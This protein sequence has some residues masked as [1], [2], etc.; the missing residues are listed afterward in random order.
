MS[1]LLQFVSH[2]SVMLR[3]GESFLLTDPWFETPAFSTWWPS[4][5]SPVSPELWISLARAGK[6]TLVISHAHPDH[7]DPGFLRR[8]PAETPVVIPHYGDDHL[9]R[10]L[11]R[12]GLR[13]LTELG[14]GESPIGPFRMRFFP[15]HDSPGDGAI[16]IELPDLFVF[17]GNDAWCLSDPQVEALRSVKPAGKPDLFMGQGGSASG[18]PLT[19]SA[20]S[21]AE[22][23][24]LL[25]K[26][27]VSMLKGLARSATE[28]GFR[29]A[30]AY[31][32]FYTVHTPERTYHPNQPVADGAY[33]NQVTG[34]DLFL[35]LSPGDLYLPAE[36]RVI[37]LYPTLRFPEETPRERVT[38]PEVSEA[39][40]LEKYERPLDDFLT[41]LRQ[42]CG[43]H[44]LEFRIEVGGRRYAVALAPR[45]SRRK[46]C[47][48]SRAILAAVL[49]RRIP[50]EDLYVGY[51][52][53]WEREPADQYN[54]AFILKL[55]QYGYA[56]QG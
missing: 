32:C 23:K 18:Y 37:S 19:Y 30:L 45:P 25:R 43:E 20:H 16:S 11:E 12:C 27:N 46:T 5:A 36:D 14:K 34:T 29:R 42:F 31:A 13:N 49:D 48:V 4:P 2:A 35:P 28:A 10:L 7:A 56:Y 8:L 38:F 41:G 26:K 55:M 1:S 47:R 50:F 3:H 22:R 53:E 51:L 6:L 52:A 15:H 17:H 39:E 54:R 44:D 40:W 24:A 33:A 21:E 9:V